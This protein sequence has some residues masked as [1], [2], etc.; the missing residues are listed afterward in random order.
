MTTETQDNKQKLF[1]ETELEDVI[2]LL[3]ENDGNPIPVLKDDTLRRAL[4]TWKH[5]DSDYR[6]DE[7][8]EEVAWRGSVSMSKSDFEA[9][10]EKEEEEMYGYEGDALPDPGEYDLEE[11]REVFDPNEMDNDQVA[12]LCFEWIKENVDILAIEEEGQDGR[13]IKYDE[14][15]GVWNE[16]PETVINSLVNTMLGRH[17]SQAITREVTNQW[18]KAEPETNVS[19]DELGLEPGYIAVENGL[20]NLLEGELERDLRAEDLALTKIPWEY[21]PESECNQFEQFLKECVEPGKIDLLQEFIGYC[22]YNGGMPFAKALLLVGSGS[23][24]KSTFINILE[25]LLGEENVMNASL[26]KLSSSRFTSYRLEGNL[27]NINADIEGGKISKTSTFKLMTGGDSF[28]V[29]QKYGDPYDHQ[30][31]AKLVFA[32]NEMPTVETNQDAFFRRWLLVDFPNK[33]TSAE[34]DGHKTADPELENKLEDEM[35]GILTVGVEG[36]Q[37]LIE[38]DGQ[39]TNELSTAEVRERWHSYNS[40]VPRFIRTHI[41]KDPEGSPT[42]TSDIYEQYQSFME[43]IPSTPASRSKL[44]ER[45]KN[46][47]EDHGYGRHRIGGK[48]VRG[49]DN[50]HIRHDSL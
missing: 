50:I 36:L 3:E 44:T 45:L 6:Y 43:N 10:I 17:S 7:F 2:E 37:R 26:S 41:E 21:D 23:N 32:A 38:S 4:A 9:K 24:G 49:F 1:A 46:Q 42:P 35:E 48:Q 14:K 39:F 30:N 8:M 40:P 13:I 18:L 25:K 19:R 16:K 11:F 15:E 28:E 33:F 5:N 34:D 29:E 12:R 27:A 47:F 22:L 20:L 31:T